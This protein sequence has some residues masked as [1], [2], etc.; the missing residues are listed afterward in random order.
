MVAD[1]E[2]I[3]MHHDSSATCMISNHVSDIIMACTFNAIEWVTSIQS[4]NGQMSPET[5]GCG[6][7]GCKLTSICCIAPR[8]ASC[9]KKL[10]GSWLSQ[11]IIESDR[12]N[13]PSLASDSLISMEIK[14]CSLWNGQCYPHPAQRNTP[15]K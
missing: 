13:N 11:H 1:S 5:F 4:K 12:M 10:H 3:F 14:I 15:G 7:S 8:T 9:E 2:H 6:K